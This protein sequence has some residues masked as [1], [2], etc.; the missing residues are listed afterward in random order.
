MITKEEFSKSTEEFEE[1]VI[2]EKEEEKIDVEKM[3]IG[4]F[5]CI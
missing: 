1:K 4:P 5:E 3:G 2:D